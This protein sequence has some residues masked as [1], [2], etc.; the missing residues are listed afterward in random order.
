MMCLCSC[1]CLVLELVHVGEICE[2]KRSHVLDVDFI[3]PCGVVVYCH[4]D[5]C[6]QINKSK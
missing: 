5:L 6:I 1:L 3:R 2:S 4:L